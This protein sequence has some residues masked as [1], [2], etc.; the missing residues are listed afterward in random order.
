MATVWTDCSCIGNSWHEVP[1]G[2]GLCAHVQSRYA[3]QLHIKG[4]AKG[5]QEHQQQWVWKQY[6]MT[7]MHSLQLYFR[8]VRAK[9]TSYACAWAGHSSRGQVHARRGRATSAPPRK[10]RPS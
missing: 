8:E 1:A 4:C 9:V 6:S 2:T 5:G 10:M 7:F 3:A